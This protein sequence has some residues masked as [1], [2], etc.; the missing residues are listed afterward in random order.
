MSRA[1]EMAVAIRSTGELS[2][3]GTN[4]SQVSSQLSCEQQ[5]C[6]VSDDARERDWLQRQEYI[7]DRYLYNDRI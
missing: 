1:S 2:V 6:S 5:Y 7:H 4:G 3:F